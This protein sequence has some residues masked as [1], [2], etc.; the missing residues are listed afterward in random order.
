MKEVRP[1]TR[2]GGS[3]NGGL[4]PRLRLIR[5]EKGH[6]L[7]DVAEGTGLS[8]SFISMVETEQSDITVGRLL[9]LLSFYRVSIGA[10]VPDEGSFASDDVVV[11]GG[12]GRHVDSPSEGVQLFL[13]APDMRRVMSPEV[14][15]FD[16]HAGVVEFDSH[17]GEEFLYVLE[18]SVELTLKGRTPVVLR[19]GDSAYYFGT[20]PHMQR[21]PT[22]R[23]AAMLV[24]ITPS[25]I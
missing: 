11:R 23:K 10:L 12:E 22:G 19:E 25:R 16:P 4:G 17:E 13:V 6:R 24:V 20:L 18:G 1:G 15:V 3:E 8:A 2:V 14:V 5:R 21:N 9:R 7:R